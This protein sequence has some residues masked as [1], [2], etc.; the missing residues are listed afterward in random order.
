VKL[1]RYVK[2]SVYKHDSAQSGIM[3]SGSVSILLHEA[4][5]AL[6]LFCLHSNTIDW[7]DHV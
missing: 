7:S 6:G 3:H 4:K 5:P 2:L 1:A